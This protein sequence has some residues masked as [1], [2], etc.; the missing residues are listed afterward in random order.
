VKALFILVPILTLAGCAGIGHQTTPDVNYYSITGDSAGSLWVDNT[1][2]RWGPLPIYE[3]P[4][5][6]LDLP[7]L[8]VDA[9]KYNDILKFSRAINIRIDQ[10][11]VKTGGTQIEQAI[12]MNNLCQN[13]T[14][15]RADIQE[16]RENALTIKGGCNNIHFGML[17]IIPGSGHCDIELG[18]AS[19]QSNLPTTEVTMDSAAMTSGAPIKLRILNATPPDIAKG[20]AIIGLFL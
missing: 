17:S 11:T 20:N 18:G 15:V 14:I 7:T 19:D 16:G 3:I 4:S 9:S 13:I 2:V 1:Q 8:G 5:I 6:V 10:V 12:D